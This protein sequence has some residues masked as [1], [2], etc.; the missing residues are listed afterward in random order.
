MSEI[1]NARGSAL[2]GI[3][4]LLVSLL[5]GVAMAFAT[6]ATIVSTSGPGDG[7]AVTDGQ[8]QPLPPEEL[9]EYGG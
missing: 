4:L 7:A 8:Q 2:S 5:A 9:L 6:A 3:I 1:V